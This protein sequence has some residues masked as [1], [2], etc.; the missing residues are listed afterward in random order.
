[1]LHKRI[2]CKDTI[3]VKKPAKILIITVT[4]FIIVAALALGTFFLVIDPNIN[5]LNSPDL[6]LD[7]MAS[8]SRTVRV[9]DRDGNV[10]DDVFYGN[11]RIY[12]KLDDLPQYTSQAF[13][14]IE[15]KRFYEHNGIDYKRVAS[16]ALSNLRSMKFKE[17]ASTITQQL[18]KNTYLSNEKTIKRKLNEMRMA[19]RLEKVYDK[20]EILESYLNILYF[21]SGIHGI[22][23]ASRIM[24]DKPASELSLAQSAALASIINNPSRYNPYTNTDNL[25]ARKK[26]VLKQMRLQGYITD[27]QYAEACNE[28]LVFNKNKRSQ[29]IGGLIKNA[30]ANFNCTEKELFLSNRTLKTEYD[31][32]IVNAV[33]EAIKSMDDFDGTVRVLVLDNATGGIACDETNENG[34]INPKRSPASAIKPFISYAPALENGSNPLTQILDEPTTFGDYM[35][36]NYR[37]RYRGF[38]SLRDCLINSSNIA[39]VKLLDDTGVENAKSVAARFGL[40]FGQSDNSLAL[41]L[42]GMENG[43]TLIDLANAYR[44][45][46]NG[47]MYSSVNYMDANKHSTEIIRAVGDDTAYLLTDILRDCAK[48]GTAKKLSGCGVIAAKTGTNG[49]DKGN[50]DCYCV[51]YTPKNTVAVWFGARSGSYIPNNITGASCCNIIKYLCER[52]ALDTSTHFRMP[53]SVA[54]FEVDDKT[55]RETHEVYL[56]DPLLPKRYRTRELFAKRHLPI[57]RSYDIIDYFDKFYWNNSDIIDYEYDTD[58]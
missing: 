14:A 44:T 38:Q 17:G 5:I 43:F 29:F 21:G 57:R 2:T 53:E 18:I 12:V 8:E 52:G 6:D 26:L 50:L 28:T 54:Y 35:P 13:I 46:A 19:R 9:L 48:R 36:H 34:Y 11:N 31:G 1:M 4:V 47:G 10:V 33:R 55:L 42:G 41:A 51:A 45:L 15:D 20:N 37:D 27:D 25:N 7:R 49:T 22:G 56:A 23:S 58:E 16:A 40:K 39:A 32:K 3:Y 30:C 24:F